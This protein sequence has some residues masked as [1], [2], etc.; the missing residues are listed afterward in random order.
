MGTTVVQLLSELY[1][2]NPYVFDRICD[3]R[4][5]GAQVESGIV[6][7]INV[8]CRNTYARF[9]GSYAR[10]LGGITER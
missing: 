2:E 4:V 10:C 7:F 8:H 3:Q 5:V 6:A 1:N 9:V